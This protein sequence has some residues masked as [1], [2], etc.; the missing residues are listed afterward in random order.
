MARSSYGIAIV[1]RDRPELLRECFRHLRES[2]NGGPKPPIWVFNNGSDPETP[3]LC[4]EYGAKALSRPGENVGFAEANNL[5]AA[6]FKGDVLLC[7]N[8]VFPMAGCLEAL[9][10]ERAK[11]C[12]IVGAKLLY[13][14][15]R[16]QHFGVGFTR[17][18]WPLHTGR[19]EPQDS[20][21]ASEPRV[22]PA[23]TGALMLIARDMWERLGGFDTAFY[24]GSEDI[25]FCLRAREA[26][27]ICGVVPDA[28]A[29]HLESQTA[30]RSAHD[31][32]NAAVYKAK[33]IDSGRIYQAL[34]VWPS[35]L[36]QPTVNYIGGPPPEAMMAQMGLSG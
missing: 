19:F 3:A 11:G 6:E 35:F 1:T 17:D 2:V 18:Y 10:R 14:D 9:A 32:R 15:G 12:D 24:F 13:P 25:D 8:D 30:G 5:L 36:Q 23:V 27:S 22:V 21:W 16:V 26:G 20:E 4:R 33:W 7:N 29:I 28:V 34:G 31:A